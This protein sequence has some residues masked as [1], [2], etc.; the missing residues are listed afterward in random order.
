MTSTITESIHPATAEPGAAGRAPSTVLGGASGGSARRARSRFPGAPEARSEASRALRRGVRW[1]GSAGALRELVEDHARAV[2]SWLLEDAA[3]G[4]GCTVVAA[5]EL[6][7]VARPGPGAGG[8]SGTSTGRLPSP[9][10]SPLLVVVAGDEV[11][12]ALWP[13][14]LEAGAHA[15]LPLPAA[16]EELL[17][18]LADLTRSRTGASVLG[19]AGGCGGAGASSFAA[20]LAGAARRPGP[21]VLLDA[22]PLGGGLDLLVEASGAEGLDW[23]RSR[24]LGP[25]DGEA[26]RAS[27][28]RIDEVHLLVAGERAGPGAEDLPRVLAA[29]SPLDG[30]VVVDLGAAQ[31]PHAAPHLDE[32]LLVVPSTPHAVRAAERRLRDW[33]LPPGLVRLVVRRGGTLTPGEVA[34]D[35]DLPLAASFRDGPRGT[36][37]LLDVRRRG[38]DRAARALL[39]ELLDG[40][41]S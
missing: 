4:A 31:V 13:R 18:R 38:A 10:R 21:V 9:A 3:D 39:A 14:A 17:S 8:R 34:E 37:P 2:G 36:V 15:V 16:S 24:A 41:S 25:D 26:L 23:S 6:D 12:A 35:L 30:T 40:V 7:A 5:E 11:P 20:R 1:V 32:L 22:D 33:P 28:P 19:V 29:L 27:L